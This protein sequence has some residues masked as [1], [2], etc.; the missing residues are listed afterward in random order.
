MMLASPS[1]AIELFAA[2]ATDRARK[3]R[4]LFFFRRLI[5]GAPFLSSRRTRAATSSVVFLVV[6]F[7]RLFII[8]VRILDISEAVLAT[9]RVLFPQVSTVEERT[10]ATLGKPVI[11][12]L[13]LRVIKLMSPRSAFPLLHTEQHI[14]LTGAGVVLQDVIISHVDGVVTARVEEPDIAC[15]IGSTNE[16]GYDAA[17]QVVVLEVR[18]L[19]AHG[20]HFKHH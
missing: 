20:E 9:F 5:Q 10:L 7:L 3:A 17:V 8:L 16:D 19:K 2:W 18:D 13:P 1:P 15:D 14:I 12:L 4:A 6:L 11:V